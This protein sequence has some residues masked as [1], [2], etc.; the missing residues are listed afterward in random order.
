MELSSRIKSTVSYSMLHELL[1]IS[2]FWSTSRVLCQCIAA[3]VLPK[4]KE[5]KMWIL[6]N[7]TH[8]GEKYNQQTKSNPPCYNLDALIL[9]ISWEG[10]L[11]WIRQYVMV[12]SFAKSFPLL[13]KKVNVYFI[14]KLMPNQNSISLIKLYIHVKKKL[15][16]N[17]AV[18]NCS[19][20]KALISVHRFYELEYAALVQESV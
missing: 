13:L 7:F 17:F 8:P 11:V 16:L 15:R 3:S 4:R 2:Q 20:F 10:G 9:W 1:Y 14:I 6:K 18:N 19:S 12:T 5:L